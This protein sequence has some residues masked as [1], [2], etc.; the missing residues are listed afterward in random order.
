M[1]QKSFHSFSIQ[2]GENEVSKFRQL[3]S[4]I[5]DLGAS[6]GVKIVPFYNESLPHF[7]KQPSLQKQKIISDLETYRRICQNTISN[8]F[9]LNNSPQFL[10]SAIREFGLR[11]TSDL[12]NYI[13]EGGII[14]VHN[15]QFIQI[16]RNFEFYGC[17]S[18]SLEE[19][20]CRPWNELYGRLPD[21]EAYMFKIIWDIFKGR[22]QTVVPMELGPHL[23]TETQ[24]PLQYEIK[25]HMKYIAP[26]FDEKTGQVAAH[27]LIEDGEVQN[28]P[29]SREEEFEKL[30]KYNQTLRLQA[31]I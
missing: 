21:V 17:C 13:S 20:Y 29:R 10:W 16:F 12:F 8:G 14:E 2:S 18:Y 3:A 9:K 28:L 7:S 22:V 31:H 23:I 26:L 25:A 1:G 30:E 4:K 15:T 19:M 11:P 6:V 5:A 27:I 24:S